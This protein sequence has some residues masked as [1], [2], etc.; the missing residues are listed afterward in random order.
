MNIPWELFQKYASGNLDKAGGEQLEQWRLRNELNELI[1]AEITQDPQLC[2]LLKNN[3]FTDNSKEW[4]NLLERIHPEIY[5]TVTLTPRIYWLTGIAAGILL[6][7]GLSV[8]WVI[9]RPGPLST[10]ADEYTYIYSP[11]GQRTQ[12]VLPDNSK[13]WLNSETSLRYPAT[14]NQKIREVTIEGEAFF[15]VA[16]NTGK[17]FF[18]NTTEL[19]I[20]VYGTSFNVKAYSGEKTIETTL[21]EGKLSVIPTRDNPGG[22]EI[23]LDP[24][25]K[26]TYIKSAGKEHNLQ[27]QEKDEPKKSAEVRPEIAEPTLELSS[28]VDVQPESSWKSGK[29]YFKDETFGELAVKLER[30]YDV[31]LH[32]EEESIK[33]YRFTGVFDKETINQAME[34]LRLSSQQSYFYHMKFRDIYIRTHK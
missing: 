11:R 31:K 19:K 27:N 26:I 2:E 29:L 17:P 9:T 12:V 7:I 6:L 3:A 20:R 16:K 1:Y 15:E 23:F 10:S 25:Q 5:K 28:N 14:F 32:F 22:K 34:A 24:Q 33:Y 18:V 30:W 8:G 13:V 21:I 4:D